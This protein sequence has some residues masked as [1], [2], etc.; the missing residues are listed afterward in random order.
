MEPNNPIRILFD[1]G[2]PHDTRLAI[3]ELK[4]GEIRFTSVR[5]D[6]EGEILDV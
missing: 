6:A 5:V 1:E 2:N 3:R 4:Q